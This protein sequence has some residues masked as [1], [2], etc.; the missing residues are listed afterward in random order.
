[1]SLYRVKKY[2]GYYK[3]AR[4]RRVSH[5]SK[6]L[7]SEEKLKQLVFIVV[8]AIIAIIFFSGS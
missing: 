4:P 1:M 6:N 3:K 8:F 2:S 7:S 5:H